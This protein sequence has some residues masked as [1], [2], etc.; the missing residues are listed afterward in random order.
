MGML[1]E[2]EAK[3]R[4]DIPDFRSL[5]KNKVMEFASML[6]RMDPEV[7]MKA[8]EQFPDFS[9]TVYSAMTDFGATLEKGMEANS[10]SS[11]QVYSLYNEIMGALRVNLEMDD[12]P[13]EQ[14]QYYLDKMLKVASLAEK[15]DAGNKQHN[16]KMIAAGAFAAATLMATLASTLGGKTNFKI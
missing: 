8:L 4:L 2:Q 9:K 15:Q 14:K 10:E 1:T 3:N 11:N 13:F 6:D 5:T 7:A 12:L 16:W